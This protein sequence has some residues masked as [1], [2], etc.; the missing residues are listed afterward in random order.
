MNG[1]AQNTLRTCV[2]PL[3]VRVHSDH[4]RAAEKER[5]TQNNQFKKSELRAI[6][7][8]IVV[9]VS[10]KTGRKER[11]KKN[12]SQT[13]PDSALGAIGST[14]ARCSWPDGLLPTRIIGHKQTSVVDAENLATLFATK[15]TPAT[16]ASC[17]ACRPSGCCIR[18]TSK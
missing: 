3:Q 4:F 9:I 2:P 11:R 17:S 15:P 1:T 10:M 5:K 8:H 13:L 7:A 6:K 14:L 18:R 16:A 12:N